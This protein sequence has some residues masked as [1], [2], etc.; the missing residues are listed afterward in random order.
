[1]AGE[2]VESLGRLVFL[3]K[4]RAV[5]LLQAAFVV[6]D[7]HGVVFGVDVEPVDGAADTHAAE[8]DGRLAVLPKLELACLWHKALGHVLLALEAMQQVAADT[9]QLGFFKFGD[10]DEGP[11][12]LG[13]PCAGMLE[14]LREHVFPHF[15]R[16][17]GR[18]ARDARALAEQV[19]EALKH[20]VAERAART[21]IAEG[22]VELVGGKFA[23]VQPT[24]GAV[25][26]RFQLAG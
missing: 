4:H 20:Q 12:L 5:P 15:A 26:E 21:G 3:G 10:G 23:L 22:D 24:H 19:V 7:E 11:L 25:D 1:M 14:A 9:A 6:Y 8:G 13:L 17:V 16:R 18:D 2:R